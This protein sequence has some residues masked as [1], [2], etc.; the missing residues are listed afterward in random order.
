MIYIAS[1]VMNIP[2]HALEIY[3][4]GC[5]RK[6]QGCQNSYIQKFGYGTPW[7]E[8]NKKNSKKYYNS[9]VSKIWILGGDLLCQEY[10]DIVYLV[11]DIKKSTRKELWLWTG[12]TL[13][14]IKKSKYLLDI[15]LMFDYIK[16]GPYDINNKE[17]V[18]YIIED[19]ELEIAG[20]NQSI[21]RIENKEFIKLPT[22]I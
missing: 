8:W 21:H 3:V 19:R 17:K 1:S 4:S 5:T 6:C 18:T 14:N 9:L 20:S 10:E 16:S 22:K 13:E 2:H 7:I 11:N 15:A 12:E